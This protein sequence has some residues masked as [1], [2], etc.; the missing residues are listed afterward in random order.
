[1]ESELDEIVVSMKSPEALKPSAVLINEV[2]TNLHGKAEDFSIIVPRELFEQNQKTRHIFDI[3]M[4]CIAG[5]S[6]LVGGIGIMNIM[7]ASILERTR[8]IGVRRAVGARRRDIWKQ[9]LVE[10]L[11]LSL[12]GGVTGIIFGFGVSRVVALYAEWS[13]GDRR[14]D[15][16]VVWRIGGSRFDLRDLP[17]VRASGLDP[18]EALRYE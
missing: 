18:V 4:S 8:E 15:R 17:A 12:L 14:L 10:A 13:T 7:L 9:F 3:V 11:V 5:I 2:L 16:A 1:M 6:L